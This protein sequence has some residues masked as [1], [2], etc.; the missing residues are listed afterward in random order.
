MSLSV[1]AFAALV[2][3]A[4]TTPPTSWFPDFAT[5]FLSL[6]VES[7]TASIPLSAFDAFATMSIFKS[8]IC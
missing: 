3:S 6:F 1:Y 4:E 7:I 5:A 8:A 2:V